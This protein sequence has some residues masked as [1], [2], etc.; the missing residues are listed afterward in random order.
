MKYD[1]F[2]LDADDTIFD[3]SACSRNALRRAMEKT[4]IPFEQGDHARY[5]A[6]NDS[7]W[8]ALERKEITHE[9]LF[10]LRFRRFLSEKGCETLSAKLNETY[11][12]CLS[13]E[14]VLLDGAEEFLRELSGMGR[15]LIVTNGTASVQ[16][17]RFR[18]FDL[19]RFA[20][21]IFISEEMGVYKPD[22]AYLE[23]VARETEGFDRSRAVVIG[24]GLTS[25]MLLAK[26]GGVDSVWF[27]P[28]KKEPKGVV[29]TFI[30]CDYAEILR[31]LRR[32]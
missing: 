26:N 15:V 14:A 16:R 31:F 3:F 9:E 8:Q 30:A 17:G 4:G 1:F 12:A 2:L 5:R 6:I 24:D 32:E 28:N 11:L 20:E 22:G 23:I 25:D 7:L 27:N 13:E 18:K 29:P 10:E 19:S 21:K